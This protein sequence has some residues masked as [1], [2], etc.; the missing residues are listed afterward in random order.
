MFAGE[1]N[2]YCKAVH[3]L[4]DG[5]GGRGWWDLGEC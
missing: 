2:I 3:F 5:G 4:R 1:E